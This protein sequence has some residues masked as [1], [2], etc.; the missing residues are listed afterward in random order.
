MGVGSAWSTG[1]VLLDPSGLSCP[2]V[3][4]QSECCLCDPGHDSISDS[5]TC[6]VQCPVS[7]HRIRVQQPLST[8]SHST[9]PHSFSSPRRGCHEEHDRPLTSAASNTIYPPALPPSRTSLPCLFVPLLCRLVRCYTIRALDNRS[10]H[11]HCQATRIHR[12]DPPLDTQ[13][14]TPTLSSL[15]CHCHCPVLTVLCVLCC[16]LYWVASIPYVAVSTLHR[17]SVHY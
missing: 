10:V 13:T 6:P 7:T 11:P 2:V 16:C 9:S 3:M 15:H 17:Q 4:W 8:H 12:T 5:H 14:C 1:S